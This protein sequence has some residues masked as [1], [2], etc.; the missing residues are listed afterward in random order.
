M[1]TTAQST[2]RAPQDMPPQPPISGARRVVRW[3]TRILAGIFLLILATL[4]GVSTVLSTH[5]GS[6]WLLAQIT[7]LINSDSLTFEYASAEGTFLRGLDMHGVDVQ[8]DDN[9]VRIEQ[10]HSRWNPMTLL[11]GEFH[12]EA[13]RI[14]GLQVNWF[15]A[16]EPVTPPEPF[17][18]EDLLDGLLP[19]PLSLRLSNTRLDGA[20]IHYDDAEFVLNAF[21]FNASL[22]GHQFDL[23]LLTFDAEPVTL[24]GAVQVEL[25]QPYPLSVELDW[26]L[27]NVLVEGTLPPSG[28]LQAAGNLDQIQ[29]SHQLAGLANLRSEGDVTLGLARLL[30][31]EAAELALQVDLEHS[32]SSQPLPGMESYVI[33][34]LQLHTRGTPENLTL[35]AGAT[36]NAGITD[37][38]VL[39]A[40]VNLNALLTGTRLQIDELAVM[41]EHGTLRVE[42]EVD[43]T[44]DINVALSYHLQDENPGDYLDALPAGMSVQALDSRGALQLT[45]SADSLAL[46]FQLQSLQA[47][48]NDYLL[49]GRADVGYDGAAWQVDNVQLSTGDNHLALSARLEA[50][51]TMQAALT[52]DAPSLGI[53]Y[54]DLEGRLDGTANVTGSLSEPV[55]DLDIQGADLRMGDIVLPELTATGQNR[56]GMNEIE[57][58]ARNLQLPVGDSA[59]TVEQLHLRLRGQ[60]DAHNILL[61]VDSSLANLRVNADGALGDGWQGRLL[62]SDIDSP[63]GHWQ[64]RQSTALTLT[65]EHLS[66]NEL[67]WQMTD[68]RLC[69]AADLQDGE[70]L[71]ASFSLTEFPLA[72]LNLPA[73]EETV[74]RQLDVDFYPGGSRSPDVRL[75]FALPDYLAVQGL[76]SAEA[77]ASGAIS[78][79]QALNISASVRT[80]GGTFYMRG[81][82][83]PEILDPADSE[84]PELV[85]NEFA[86][87]T[88][89]AT[90]EQLAGIWQLNSQLEFL[91]EDPQ[92]RGTSMRGAASADIRMDENQTLN[93]E[94]VLNFD[95]LG[96]LE[97]FAPQI[98]AVSGQLNGRLNVQ[99][100][101]DSP[102]IGSD[103]SLAAAS[104]DVPALG[105]S[106][107]EIEASVYSD[108]SEHFVMAGQALSGAGSMNFASDLY[109]PLTPNR[110]LELRLAGDNFT[111]AN[112]S[113]LQI[114]ISP[115]LQMDASDQN[116]D[117]GGELFIPLVDARITT[118]P[119]SA[120]DVS[121]DV[122][123]VGQPVDEPEVR[124][125]AQ[126][127][128][129]PFGDIPVNADV[130]IVLGDNVRVAGFGLNTRL[131]GQLDI[132]QRPGSPPLTYGELE[133][134]D[135]SFQIYGRV[136]T[137]EQGRVIFLGSYDNPAID[138]RAVREVEN[139][140]VGMQ[141]SGTVRNIRSNLFSTPSLSDGDILSVI[142]T[143]RPIAEIGTQQDGNALVSA[144]TS[145]G[146]SQGRGI[147][148]Q[149]QNQL[150]LDAFEIDSRGDVNDSSLMLGKYITPRIF[151]RYAVGLFETENS[152]AIDYTVTDRVK[153]EAVSG[154]TQS[155]DLT[156]TLER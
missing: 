87:P 85:I 33:E 24:Q 156:Y 115:D 49:T 96:W 154:Q 11:D 22:Q 151:L 125:A 114:A 21:A 8:I 71:Q 47:T 74:A 78:D 70:Q 55:I 35:T 34:A 88:F 142:I 111:I 106:L 76:V 59:E 123:L 89:N 42:G 73:A 118:L 19:L 124:N 97:A 52:I 67:C 84:V 15:S 117:I 104:F 102:V 39:A 144:I 68:T 36:V 150:G 99:G 91:H 146:I 62:S 32:L 48:V 112:L 63:Y 145:L 72:V 137:I 133:V 46:T 127:E 5:A 27:N 138:I 20:T 155:I 38:L 129:S 120:T 60:P 121:R 107:S 28:Q 94:V 108:D 23:Q 109:E 90:A 2:P 105:L 77:S 122:V 135:G 31:N 13:L 132:N 30:N 29:L 53:L 143:G 98:T 101:L 83:E 14:A 18:L 75:P 40:D 65:P 43:W 54:P 149:I 119:E 103:I 93:G 7:T 25:I 51:E 92:A 56:A 147:T 64:Q 69:L 113:E 79:L 128:V 66:V 6:H 58:I 126:T 152:L 9:R 57:L 3:V 50:D 140:R 131:R 41:L 130:R 44:S 100:R 136:L 80:E 153:V 61:R 12:L 95:D 139:M 16:P 82:P 86:W 134:A 26:Q 45:Q 1:D 110:R 37:T 4:I 148:N 81:E 141:M 116:I 17:V 10:L